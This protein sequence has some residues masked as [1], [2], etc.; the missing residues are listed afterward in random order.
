MGYLQS[1]STELWLTIIIAI[2]GWAWAI[3]QIIYKRKWQKKDALVA[4]R[5]DAYF[6]YMRK[7]EEINE[8]MRKDPRAIFNIAQEFVTKILNGNNKEIN[9]DLIEF[10][11]QLLD[12]FK[13]ACY[14]LTI[15][16]QES[17]SLLI[18]ASKELLRKVEEQKKLIIDFNNEM[19]NCLN[20][21]NIKDGNSFQ[22]LNTIGQDNRWH[23]LSSLNNEIITLMRKEIGI[24]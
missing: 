22:V 8:N 19:Q 15:I 5:Y 21:I 1:M 14:L 18:I 17:N 11:Q 12:Y 23:R 13:R 6:Q 3:I 2:I 10:N 16:N 7:C 9:D 24:E 4:R 20:R